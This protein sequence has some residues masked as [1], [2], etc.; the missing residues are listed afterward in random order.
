MQPQETDRFIAKMVEESIGPQRP[1]AVNLTAAL[2]FS[3]CYHTCK[4]LP[5]NLAKNSSK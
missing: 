1:T 2:N 4:I 5:L 3:V